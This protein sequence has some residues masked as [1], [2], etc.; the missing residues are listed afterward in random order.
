MPATKIA[1]F[2][3]SL[4]LAGSLA[5]CGGDDGDDAGGGGGG[6]SSGET[7]SAES[8]AADVCGAM[9]SWVSGIQQKTTELTESFTS[10]SPEEGKEVLVGLFE[11]MSAQ[12]G[13]LITAV[14]EAGVPDVEGGEEVSEDFVAAFTEAQ[15][16]LDSAQ[17]DIEA[18]PSDPQGFQ[19]GAAELGPRLQ[20]AIS[21]IGE[22][23]SEPESQEL[24]DAVEQEEACAAV[25][26]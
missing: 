5:A 18:L 9:K 16:I 11:E 22:S 3:V 17:G 25:P 21:S 12:T 24:R 26:G 4:L 6:D 10:G 20:E 13:D 15:D 2:A 1:A 7:V 14:E 8:W 23:I 19:E